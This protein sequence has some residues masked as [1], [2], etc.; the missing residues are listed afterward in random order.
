[1]RFLQP[2]AALLNLTFRDF[3]VKMTGINSAFRYTIENAISG[4][5]PAFAINYAQA[6]VSR[7]DL[8]NVL[9]PAVTSGAGSILTFSWTDNSGVGAAQPTD[10]SILVAY[11]PAMKQAIY[12]GGEMRSALTGDLNLVA[13]SG[14]LV[15]TYI[16]PR[17]RACKNHS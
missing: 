17:L 6:L 8:P 11:C 9:G 15:E 13:F 2:M 5:Y 1:M 14:Q 4:T 7:G 12:A 16:G 10:E 3:A